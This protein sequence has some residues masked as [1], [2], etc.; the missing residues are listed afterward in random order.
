MPDTTL[1]WNNAVGYAD[2]V[3]SGSVLETGNDLASAIIIS[4]FSDRMA[5][6]G[7]IIPDGSNDPRGWWADGDVLI[8][9][10]MWL[11]KRAKQT[12]KT[13]Q[14]AYDYLAEA[15]QWL[16]DDAVVARFDIQTQ[17]VRTGVLGASITAWSPTGTQLASGLYTWAWNGIS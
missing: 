14:D 6:P 12:L 2:W 1:T 8:G 9:S 17:W 13:L 3:L 15:L 5:Q 11:L 16:I 7:D 10:R 4:I